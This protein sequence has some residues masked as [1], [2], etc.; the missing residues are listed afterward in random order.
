[1][2]RPKLESVAANE[3]TEV[4]A[5]EDDCREPT[6]EKLL[7][8]LRIGLREAIAGEEGAPAREAIKAL[9]ERVYRDANRR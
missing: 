7:E 6:K 4:T 2:D 8:D 9:R 3:A 1:M 5:P